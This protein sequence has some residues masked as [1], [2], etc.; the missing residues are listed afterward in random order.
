MPRAGE[1]GPG[2]ADQPRLAPRP[3]RTGSLGFNPRLIS[4]RVVYLCSGKCG[5]LLYLFTSAPKWIYIV[6]LMLHL[7]PHKTSCSSKLPKGANS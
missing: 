3:S 6:T 2:A 4:V 7:N 5:V 1:P